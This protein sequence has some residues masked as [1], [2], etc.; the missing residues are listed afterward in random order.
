MSTLVAMFS[1]DQR[2]TG[3][4]WNT[5][6]EAIAVAKDLVM[7]FETKM[8]PGVKWQKGKLT[9]LDDGLDIMVVGWAVQDDSWFP[10]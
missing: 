2:V 9:R 3:A 5:G 8:D 7:L 4:S 6:Q 10:A 1:A